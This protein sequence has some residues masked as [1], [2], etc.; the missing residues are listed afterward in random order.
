[1]RTDRIVVVTGAAGGMGKLAVERFLANG[2][3]V[4]ATDTS[5]NALNALTDAQPAG[6]KLHTVVGDISKEEDCQRV[7]ERALN[8]GGRVDVLVNVAGFFPMQPFDE[9][10]AADFRKVIDI[11][12]TGTFLMIKAMTPLMRGRNWGRIVNI[13]SASTFEGVAD[14]VHYVAAKSGLFG[15]SRSLAR[16]LGKDGITVNV[17]TP[18]L[19]VTPAVK[20]HM[21]PE[22]IEQQ[23]KSRAI[24][25]E[26]KGE[27][28]IGA[29]FFLASP[30]SDFISGQTV[31]VDGGKHML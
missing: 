1:M 26:E 31:N 15:L 7:A 10:T 6:S 3:T 21:P 8:V 9:M 2:D 18:G 19:T 16:V 22:L 14:Q 17:V 11:N 12:L 29:I 4:V 28:L 13:G 23:I 27:D 30:D 5:D 24:A 25:R 20:A